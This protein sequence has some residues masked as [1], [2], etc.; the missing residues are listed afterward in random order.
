MLHLTHGFNQV[1]VNLPVDSVHDSYGCA[2]AGIKHLGFLSIKIAQ[3]CSVSVNILDATD[4][5]FGIA[6]GICKFLDKLIVTLDIPRTFFHC[7]FRE[8]I[9]FNGV[10]AHSKVLTPIHPG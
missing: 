3:N 6:R 8:Y 2:P 9:I 10:D 5:R 1:A 7:V 4:D